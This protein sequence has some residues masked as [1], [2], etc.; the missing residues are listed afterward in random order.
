MLESVIQSIEPRSIRTLLGQGLAVPTTR[1]IARSRHGFRMME[2]SGTVY[3]APTGLHMLLLRHTPHEHSPV[4][5]SIQHLGV[6]RR[7]LYA[8]STE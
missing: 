7:C 1:Q 2:S 6:F 3:L 8:H 4:P 5:L